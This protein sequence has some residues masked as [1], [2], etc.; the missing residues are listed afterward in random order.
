MERRHCQ[1]IH[2]PRSPTNCD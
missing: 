1:F 2:H